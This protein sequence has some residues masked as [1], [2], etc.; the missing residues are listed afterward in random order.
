MKKKLAITLI[1]ILCLSSLAVFTACDSFLDYLLGLT[2]NTTPPTNVDNADK[3]HQH[4]LEHK[5]SEQ[6]TCTG[7]G[8][9]EYWYCAGCGKY[10]ADSAAKQEIADISTTAMGHQYV[11]FSDKD[12]HWQKCRFCGDT[13]PSESHYSEK[14][15]R[16]S[17]EHGKICDVC[18]YYFES[19]AHTMVDG[20]CK[21]CGYF[22]DYATQC[23]STYGYDYFATLQ[24]GNNLQKFYNQIDDQVKQFHN[25]ADTN[26]VKRKSDTVDIY[27]LTEVNFQ[28]FGLSLEEALSVWSTYKND[29]PIYYWMSRNVI[30]NEVSLL[31]IG[32][33]ENYAKGN[34]RANKNV[35]LYAEIDEYLDSV[36]SETDAYD[37]TLA[38]HDKIINNVKYAR[39]S[40]GAA[41]N[42]EWAHNIL[43]VFDNK[44]AVCEGYARAFQL[45]LNARS[46]PNVL[47]TGTVKQ[48]NRNEGHAWN[49]AQLGEEWYWYDLTW[50]DQPGIPGGIIYNYFCQSGQ[51]LDRH[52]AGGQIL[53]PD[54]LYKLPVAANDDYS[55]GLILGEKFTVDNVQYKLCGYNKVS[56]EKCNAF[57]K[58]EIPE[59]VTYGD[60]SYAVTQIGEDAFG[61]GLTNLVI[62]SSVEI[63]YNYAFSNSSRLVGVTFEDTVGWT[64]TPQIVDA[65]TPS[66]VSSQSLSNEANAASLLKSY[67]KGSL[68][69]SYQY[70]WEKN[71]QTD[72]AE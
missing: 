70:V 55:G 65:V 71:A 33:D 36:A 56:L 23:S 47:V 57:G 60:Q 41:E 27:T 59:S 61:I 25:N 38:F 19:A 52:V 28:K 64:R 5:T 43:G 7:N 12:S 67:Y 16:Y 20:T 34:V 63:I 1:L 29:H 8:T 72:N 54:Y 66:A 22:A 15:V 2:D 32:V 68:L 31:Y 4:T 40:S 62:P 6:A 3:V 10:Y 21:V 42:E 18:S 53:G 26:A 49:M 9:V 44:A 39:T 69:M 14:Y 37:I 35:E 51:S 50:D 48:N 46:I 11:Y 17:N 30:H 24:K 58:F 13:L 45:L